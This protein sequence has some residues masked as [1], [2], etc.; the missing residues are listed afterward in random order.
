MGDG[1]LPRLVSSIELLKVRKFLRDFY[2]ANIV[3]P[4]FKFTNK[5][6]D[7]L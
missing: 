1:K 4:K 6:Y 7:S 3:F 5:Y 2:F